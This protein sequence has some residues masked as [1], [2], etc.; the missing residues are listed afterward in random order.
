MGDER[1]G[2][3]H[4]INGLRGPAHSKNLYKTDIASTWYYKT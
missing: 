3:C 1:I 2:P 4:V